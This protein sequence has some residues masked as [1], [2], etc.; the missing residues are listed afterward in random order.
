MSRSAIA[1]RPRST[2]PNPLRKL[3]TSFKDVKRFAKRKEEKYTDRC[4][5]R[6]LDRLGHYSRC[7][8]DDLSYK[9]VTD[10][11]SRI[12]YHGDTNDD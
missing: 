9:P 6:C 5:N 8:S 1:R 7:V 4:P 12:T 10:H 3:A 2:S 11:S